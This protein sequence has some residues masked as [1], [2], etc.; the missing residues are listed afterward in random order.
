MASLCMIGPA[1]EEG[2]LQNGAYVQTQQGRHKLHITGSMERGVG[3][4]ASNDIRVWSW[5]VMDCRLYIIVQVQVELKI[6]AERTT[7]CICLY[8]RP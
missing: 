1:K 2:T 7:G 6:C 4:K 3:H 8:R 5:K